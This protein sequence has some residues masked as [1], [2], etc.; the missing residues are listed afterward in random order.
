MA[1]V[2]IITQNIQNL[3]IRQQQ[4]ERLIQQT[5]VHN[6]Q[7]QMF[8][9]DL[10]DY[11]QG[12]SVITDLVL[13]ESTEQV[14]DIKVTAIEHVLSEQRKYLV[15][16]I[17]LLEE[18]LEEDMQPAL[19]GQSSGGLRRILSSLKGLVE[20]NNYLSQDNRTFQRNYLSEQNIPVQKPKQNF[21]KRLFGKS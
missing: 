21:L 11:N 14:D 17:R 13:E 9:F 10:T 7:L 16:V 2:E 18:T 20:M 5:E 3:A 15:E 1:T 19:L 6:E 8:L 12:L 4:L